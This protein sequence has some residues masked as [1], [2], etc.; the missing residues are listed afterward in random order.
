MTVGKSG[1]R[2][3][4]VAVFLGRRFKSPWFP[5]AHSMKSCQ[6]PL[7]LL[8][9]GLTLSIMNPKAQH[10]ILDS[11]PSPTH[12]IYQ[13]LRCWECLGGATELKKTHQE[14]KHSKP[15]LLLGKKIN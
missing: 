15:E 4:H 12:P 3:Q 1:P 14:K 13:R 7:H 5:W 2:S 11:A 9:R 6:L 10:Q 8:L